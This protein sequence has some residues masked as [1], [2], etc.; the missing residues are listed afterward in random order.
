MGDPRLPTE[1]PN[2]EELSVGTEFPHLTHYLFRYPAKFHPPVVH[3][4]LD[5]YT[6]PGSTILDP[7]VGS[8]TLLVE[9]VIAGRSAIGV[10]VDPVAVAVSNA[11]AGRYRPDVVRRSAE[12]IREVLRPLVRSPEEYEKRKFEDLSDRQYAAQ[13]RKVKNWV[14]AIPNLDHWF[15]RYVIVDLARIRQGIAEAN[16]PVSHRPLLDVV[17]ASIIRNASNADPVPVSGLEVTSYMKRRDAEGRLVNPFTLFDRA[18][19]K[20]I[21]MTSA[22]YRHA[23]PGAA[24]TATIG[25]ATMVST[26]VDRPVDAVITSPP[27]HG[28][29]DYYRRH[30]LE[31]FWLGQVNHQQDRL[32]L[33]ERYIGRPKVPQSHYFVSSSTVSTA[34]AKEWERKIRATDT[35]RADAFRHYMVA[36]TLCFE[37]LAHLLPAGAPAIFIVGHSAW[38]ST[39]IPTTDLF[40]EIAGE[41]F[42]LQELLSYPVKNRYMSYTRHNDASIS[43]E[44]VLVFRRSSTSFAG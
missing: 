43:R 16:I 41:A 7:F 2:C 5:R 17:F 22:F 24:A 14:P 39:E 10:D 20:T 3:A 40:A 35:E 28:A 6:A 30:Q 31:M 42:D 12:T 38:N 23:R 33:L 25:D 9:A 36:M 26:V 8:G 29:V 1:L 37:E 19:A 11:K 13:L 44:Y 32:K 4:L 34:L 15:R 27:Y 21:E 18:L